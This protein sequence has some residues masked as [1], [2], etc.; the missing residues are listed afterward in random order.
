LKEKIEAWMMSPI[1]KKISSED[2]REDSRRVGVVKNSANSVKERSRHQS[3][4]HVSLVDRWSPN[5][6]KMSVAGGKMSVAGVT[7]AAG[8]SC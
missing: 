3:V 5:R 4:D 7:R 8:D 2:R 1:V 6:A